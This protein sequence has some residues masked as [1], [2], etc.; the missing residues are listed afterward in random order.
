MMFDGMDVIRESFADRP[1]SVSSSDPGPRGQNPQK[2]DHCI[3][4]LTGDSSCKKKHS[5]RPGYMRRDVEQKLPH[6]PFINAQYISPQ[7][8]NERKTCSNLSF[9]NNRLVECLKNLKHFRDIKIADHQSTASNHMAAENP[10]VVP[11]KWPNMMTS[12]NIQCSESNYKCTDGCD[13]SCN[14]SIKTCSKCFSSGSFLKQNT[15]LTQ[16]ERENSVAVNKPQAV[17]STKKQ[18]DNE[19]LQK[20]H[21]WDTD[22]EIHSS[23]AFISS[24]SFI[25][26]SLN[27]HSNNTN[28]KDELQQ[29][30]F[31]SNLQ[32]PQ[33]EPHLRPYQVSTLATK[34][35]YS[36]PLRDTVDTPC[37]HLCQSVDI[38]CATNTE[39]MGRSQNY[40]SLLLE[41]DF[42]FLCP[43]DY[44]DDC[45]GSAVTSRH[46]SNV[47]AF[48]QKCNSLRKCKQTL[49]DCL[50]ENR[51]T[52][53]LQSLILKP[54]NLQKKVVMEDDFEKA[55]QFNKK[56]AELKRGNSLKFQLPSSHPCIARFVQEIELQAQVVDHYNNTGNLVQSVEERFSDS[57]PDNLHM[58]WSRKKQLIQDR[59]QLQEE[60]TDLKGQL[61]VLEAKDHQLCVE[62]EE[63][64]RLIQSYD[65]ELPSLSTASVIELQDLNKTLK[66][67]LPLRNKILFNSKLPEDVKRLQQKEQSL[68]MA[69]KTATAKIFSSQKQCS[70]LSRK[71]SDIEMQLPVLS[72]AKMLAISGHEFSTA[73]A[74]AEEIKSLTS[75]KIGLQE[76]ISDL[77]DFS[78]KKAEQFET[79][80]EE[81]NSLRAQL[82]QRENLF[83]KNLKENIIKYM[84]ALQDKLYNCGNQVLAKVWEA[85]LE[86][87]QLF[88]KSLQLQEGSSCGPEREEFQGNEDSSAIEDASI[89]VK[90]TKDAA[91][92]SKQDWCVKQ[93]S[94]PDENG[95]DLS[96]VTIKI[97][98]QIVKDTQSE[99]TYKDSAVDIELQCETISHKLLY[100][101]DQLH[102]A[103]N[104]HDKSLIQHLQRQIQMIKETLQAMLKHLLPVEEEEEFGGFTV[105]SR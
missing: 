51:M 103:M 70:K 2:R 65:C 69:I 18:V 83:E 76:L 20:L 7:V 60:I 21:L 50:L 39:S 71:A 100:L 8:E 19:N 80:R 37:P 36:K 22:E 3:S 38:K 43:V 47:T 10:V 73:N 29:K 34:Q 98:F 59:Q 15:C 27:Y 90:D 82:E 53:K 49:Q 101:E 26:M 48:D 85:D 63:E 89:E 56:L 23:N 94:V 4:V 68:I 45:P 86:A 104:S 33:T 64:T 13:D 88:V 93:R 95:T 17:A 24:F 57:K 42:S 32:F 28:R 52:F 62:I 30:E 96:K 16:S 92:L 55:D 67:V 58:S 75:K 25:Q 46:E 14:T 44:F 78:I 35:F 9:N 81:Y 72:E 102:T 87:C 79:I 99:I 40:D 5:K 91:F 97:L 54:K 6:P 74:L 105:N 66:D 61:A 31:V 41:K 11:S 12:E 77:Q 1:R 84:K